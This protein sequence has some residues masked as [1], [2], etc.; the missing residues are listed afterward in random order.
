MTA[1]GRHTPF[2]FLTGASLLFFNAAAAAAQD[3]N[4]DTT[5]YFSVEALWEVVAET[6]QDFGAWTMI[7]VVALIDA[8]PFCPTQPASIVAGAVLGFPVGLPVVIVGQG[9]AT[10]LALWVGRYVWA[11]RPTAAASEIVRVKRCSLDDEEGEE[12]EK[13]VSPSS[14]SKPTKMARVLEEMASGLN[15]DDWK[16]VFGTMLLARQSP[17]L[18]FSVGNYFIGASTKAPIPPVVLATMIGCIPLNCLWVGAGA[19][20]TAAVEAMQE[21]DSLAK[22]IQIIGFA[23]TAS[24][25]MLIGKVVYKVWK[26]DDS[27]HNSTSKSI[28]E[29]KE[30]TLRDLC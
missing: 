8:I 29:E 5:S 16:T 2:L 27:I 19:G 11:A 28:L 26:E 30:K 22:G 9:L 1:S 14:S 24:I 4:S 6:A 10:A 13:L 3:D 12:Q 7:L 17:V 23:A 25:V 20:G 18:P 21:H 15:S